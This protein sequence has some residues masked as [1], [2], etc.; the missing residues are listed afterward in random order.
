MSS[1]GAESLTGD[2]ADG[3]VYGG[4]DGGVGGEVT[5]GTASGGC[6]RAAGGGSRGAG[7]G[8]ESRGRA[9]VRGGK[10][11]AAGVKWMVVER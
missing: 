11:V 4:K 8:K 5:P 10:G 7:V 6:T 1:A 3:K 9:G 2:E